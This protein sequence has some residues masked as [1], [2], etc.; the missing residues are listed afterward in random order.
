[1]QDLAVILAIGFAA[2]I[3]SGLVGIGGGV[4]LVPAMVFFLAYSQKQA[5]GTTLA[6]LLFPVVALGVYNYYK[7]G[8]VEWRTALLLGAGFVVGG[9]LGSRFAVWMP[10][11]VA[12]GSWSVNQP[13]Q[14][15]F[16]VFMVVAAVRL[17][18]K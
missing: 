2:G 7:S 9:Y 6:M 5:Q 1:M 10:N 11:S 8:F 14:K 15:L 13:L 3:L 16:A 17:F 18:L 4:V 12:L